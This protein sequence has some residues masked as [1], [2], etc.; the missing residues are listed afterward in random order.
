MNCI[1][2]DSAHSAAINPAPAL[3]FSRGE[4]RADGRGDK[5]KEVSLPLMG[6]GV[7]SLL[8]GWRVFLR[9]RDGLHFLI[10]GPVQ[11]MYNR[12]MTLVLVIPT[13]IAI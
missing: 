7:I 5:G 1:Y 12:A 9:H 8:L 3:L 10:A 2:E 11:Q 13:L 4:K 6:S